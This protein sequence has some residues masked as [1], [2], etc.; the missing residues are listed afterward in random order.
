MGLE[1][2]GP[3][4]RAFHLNV[5]QIML[6]V[7]SDAAPLWHSANGVCEDTAPPL[8]LSFS[9]TSCLSFPFSPHWL[10]H[11]DPLM[12]F[13]PLCSRFMRSSEAA[14]KPKHTSITAQLNRQLGSSLS[15]SLPF[16]LYNVPQQASLLTGIKTTRRRELTNSLCCFK[17]K[18]KEKHP[19][20]SG[21]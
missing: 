2:L 3:F 4:V 15:L 16:F 1:A 20:K 9:L 19:E 10:T 13:F 21:K 5:A 8:L 12:L 11:K 18:R 7:G 14:D 17:K 6:W